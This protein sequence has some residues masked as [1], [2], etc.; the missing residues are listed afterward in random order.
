M[1]QWAGS[2]PDVAGEW[3]VGQSLLV[4][5]NDQMSGLANGDAGVVISAG[6]GPSVVAFPGTGG[7]ML[8]PTV[9]LDEVTALDAMTVHRGQGSQYSS[10]TIV[11]PPP[12][13]PLLTRELLYTAVTR[14][15]NKVRILGDPESIRAAVTRSIE[16][17]SRMTPRL[18]AA[19]TPV[20]AVDGSHP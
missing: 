6:D 16:R 1:R 11:L 17:P 14:A 10:V 20:S 15:R 4:T 18:V 9:R 8:I 5:A 7:P 3:P 12:T 2:G 19:L 13:S